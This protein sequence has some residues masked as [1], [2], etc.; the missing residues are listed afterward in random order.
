MILARIPL[1]F[2][3]AILFFYRVP[4]VLCRAD[5]SGVEMEYKEARSIALKEV[6]QQLGEEEKLRVK[7]EMEKYS[8]DKDVEQQRLDSESWNQKL[9][10]KTLD[11]AYATVV[12]AKCVRR[13]LARRVMI[14]RCTE[15]YEKCFDEHHHA[16]YYRNLITV[17]RITCA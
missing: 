10:Q 14:E 15:R 7:C 5:A 1:T 6:L 8:S 17:R 9:K 4:D 12:L 16:F 11:E 2:A 13:W 3:L